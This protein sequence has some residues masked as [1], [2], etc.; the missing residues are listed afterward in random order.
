MAYTVELSKKAQKQLKT[1]PQS[2]Q[3]RLN[4]E[5]S[6]LAAQPRPPGVKA[7]QGTKGLL[8]LKVGDYRIIYTVEDDRLL[9]VVVKVGHRSKVYRQL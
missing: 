3:K 4:V 5:I 1:L 7:L 8:R 6:A 9:V 2:V